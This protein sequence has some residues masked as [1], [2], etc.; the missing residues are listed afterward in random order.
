VFDKK[1]ENTIISKV[2]AGNLKE[3]MKYIN[4]PPKW[5]SAKDS[6]VLNFNGRVTEA[7][8]KNFQ[9]IESLVSIF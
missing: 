6:Y 8:V 5:D 4:K 9:I 2:K 7:S 1:D 3:L